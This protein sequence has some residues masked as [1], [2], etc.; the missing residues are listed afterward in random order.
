MWIVNICEFRFE[1]IA[2]KTNLSIII[3]TFSFTMLGFIATI[4]TVLFSLRNS[5]NF[6]NYE[7]RG[8]LD[9]FWLLYRTTIVCLF[10]TFIM[11]LFSFS[12][13]VHWSIFDLMLV[14][15]A[16][17]VVQVFW[18]TLILSGLTQKQAANEA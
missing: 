14:F 4:V 16:N 18:L 7:K 8:R 1:L 11:A 6:K 3:A 17:N 15:F 10:F 2:Q 5:R 9:I 12:K 13:N